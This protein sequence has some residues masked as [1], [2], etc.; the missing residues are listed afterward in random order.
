MNPESREM[1]GYYW[2][3]DGRN[4]IYCGMTYTASSCEDISTNNPETGDRSSCGITTQWTYCDMTIAACVTGNA[5]VG[6]GWRRIININIIAGDDCPT[7]W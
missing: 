5:G 7:G 4:K 2:I 3:L 6:G 1:S